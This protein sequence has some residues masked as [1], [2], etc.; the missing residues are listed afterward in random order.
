MLF[1]EGNRGALRAAAGAVGVLMRKTD[2]RRSGPVRAAS[3][4]LLA[5][6]LSVSANAAPADEADDD[7]TDSATVAEAFEP[8]PAKDWAVTIGT[9][10]RLTSS[11]TGSRRMALAPAPFYDVQW[12]NL[13]F[14]SS[15]KGL[16]LNL[17]RETGLLMPS[18]RFTLSASV[19]ANNER[20]LI[21]SLSQYRALDI[22]G[23]YT[24]YLVGR[25]EYKAGN[26]LAF[27]EADKFFD[28][29]NGSVL[30]FGGEYT[31]PLTD[32]WSMIMMASLSFGSTV[33][34]QENYGVPQA[35]ALAIGKPAVRLHSGPRDAT[36]ATEFEYQADRHW[37]YS[38]LAGY[39]RLL[40]EAA[41]SYRIASRA[42]PFLGTSI[43]YHF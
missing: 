12:K 37:S 30:S 38:L 25:A 43:K 21:G 42:Q 40:G 34:M 3:A 7:E 24:P 16:G 4:L 17:L 2:H 22:K 33:H 18:D 13:A 35:F 11:R 26:W 10:A 15:E 41:E 32:K 6:G 27:V 19:N 1:A 23:K 14:L 39:T 29:N 9:T 5:L 31:Q 8:R 28:L 36:I 20:S